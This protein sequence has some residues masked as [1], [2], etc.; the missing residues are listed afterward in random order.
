MEKPIRV[1]KKLIA[2]EVI[3]YTGDN[4]EALHRF[5]VPTQ[6]EIGIP[7]ALSIFVAANRTYVPIEVGEWVAKDD[8]GFYPIKDEI[9]KANFTQVGEF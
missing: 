3:Q 1:V 2:Q 9:M 4:R 5:G 6:I 8:L 7:S